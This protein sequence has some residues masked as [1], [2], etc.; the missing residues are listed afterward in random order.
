MNFSDSVKAG[1]LIK[2]VVQNIM[3]PLNE[4]ITILLDKRANDEKG[5][6]PYTDQEITEVG[7]SL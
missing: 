1:Q 3:Y 2:H 6:R 5:F 7:D 4:Q